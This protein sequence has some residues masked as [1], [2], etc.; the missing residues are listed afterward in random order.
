MQVVTHPRL[1]SNPLSEQ[2]QQVFYMASYDCDKFRRMVFNSRFLSLFQLSEER[3]R[4]IEAGES[5]LLKLAFDWMRFSLL[6]E[7][8]LKSSSV[9]RSGG[10]CPNHA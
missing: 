9:P 4:E 2:Q 6:G 1:R 3:V 8:A 10:C 7:P 5:A